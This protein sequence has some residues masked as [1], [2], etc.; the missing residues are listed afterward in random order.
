MVPNK[1]AEDLSF[2]GKAYLS[3]YMQIYH[4]LKYLIDELVRLLSLDFD[5]TMFIYFPVCS[6]ILL[7]FFQSVRL[8]HHVCLLSWSKQ[9]SK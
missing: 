8:L 9:C 5:S 1:H 3:S 2:L 6:F 4:T 7:P